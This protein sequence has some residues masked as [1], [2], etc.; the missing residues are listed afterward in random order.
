MLRKITL[1]FE[2]DSFEVGIYFLSADF[3]DADIIITFW[4]PSQ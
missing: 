1:F 4:A 2:L 3:D